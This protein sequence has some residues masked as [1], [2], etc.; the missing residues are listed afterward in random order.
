MHETMLRSL[1]HRLLVLEA[2]L[3][4]WLL[5]FCMCIHTGQYGLFASPVC[6]FQKGG[7]LA[8]LGALAGYHTSGSH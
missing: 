3:E 2:P 5:I 8:S 4:A 7:I 6:K 1:L